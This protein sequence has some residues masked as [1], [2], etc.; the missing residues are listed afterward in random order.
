MKSEQINSVQQWLPF[1]R[2]LENGI[3]KLKDS[4]YIKILKVTPINY[5]LKSDL[6]KEAILNSYKSFIKSCNFDI[7]ILIQSKKED[8][9]KHIQ[10]L[11]QNKFYHEIK[12]KYIQYINFLNQNKKSSNK[13]FYI[14]IKKT[15]SDPNNLETIVIQNL[16]EEFFKIKETLAR[17]GNLVSEYTEEKQIRDILYSFLNS[18]IFLNE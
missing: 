2:I 8:L 1:E 10:N 15:T 7:Q 16:Q 3:I 5:S 9:T 6:E 11:N 12:E 18:R 17:C 14:I 4:S 13:N